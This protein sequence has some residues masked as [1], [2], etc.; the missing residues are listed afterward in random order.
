MKRIFDFNTRFKPDRFHSLGLK[1]TLSLQGNELRY[2]EKELLAGSGS[3]M[4]F[5][6]IIP[7]FCDIA[8]VMK[9]D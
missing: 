4:R 1:G 9:L 7:E 2:A 6:V 5:G 3:L 8:D